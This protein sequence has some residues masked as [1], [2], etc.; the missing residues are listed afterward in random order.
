MIQKLLIEKRVR[1]V[2]DLLRTAGASE[3]MLVGGWVRDQILGINSKDYDVEVYGLGY[4]EIVEALR[5]RYSVNLVGKSFGVVKIGDWLDIS[6]PRRESKCGLGH[7]GFEI[8][9]DPTL[10]PHE[11]TSRRD[12]TVNAIGLRADGTLFDPYDGCGDLEQGILRAP[13]EAFCEDPLRVLRG[14]QFA[15]R[16]GFRME[17]RTVEMCRSVLPEFDELAAERIWGEWH[18]WAERGQYPSHGLNILRQTGWIEK[19]P[20]LAAIESVPYGKGKGEDLFEHTCRVCDAV[21]SLIARG[22]FSLE[23]RTVLFFSALC[24]D[25]GYPEA[26][27]TSKPACEIGPGHARR[28]RRLATDFLEMMRAPG[29]VVERVAPLVR[30]HNVTITSRNELLTARRLRWMAHALAPTSLRHW[31]TL[32][33]AH[34]TAVGA[35]QSTEAKRLPELISQAR[36]LGVWEQAPSP[37]IQGRDLIKWGIVPGPEMGPILKQA[38]RAQLNGAFDDLE[39]GRRWFARISTCKKD[40]H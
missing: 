18:K 15:A 21:A 28:G 17:E 33:E 29:W 26:I 37:L 5:P 7:R 14:M 38:F 9:S 4:D 19:F 11:A 25:W 39:G 40:L 32:R 31:A 6:L 3:C 23:D 20:A 12:F 35:S 27:L 24:H 8:E 1:N 2:L 16:L 36:T 10:T 22:R 30:M 13:T 34:L